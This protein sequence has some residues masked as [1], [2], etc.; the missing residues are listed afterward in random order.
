MKKKTKKKIKTSLD[1][2]KSETL[3]MEGY[4]PKLFGTGRVVAY[5][6]KGLINTF[7]MMAEW[8]N[9]EGFDFSFDTDKD[10]PKRI[11]LHVDEIETMLRCLEHMDYF[12]VID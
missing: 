10:Q 1:R 6:T 4:Q 8:P 9:G 11:S 3:A 12:N 7:C 2:I 5:E